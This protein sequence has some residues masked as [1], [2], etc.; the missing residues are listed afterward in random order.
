MLKS[1]RLKLL[2]ALKATLWLSMIQSS[3]T[4][5]EHLINGNEDGRG[6][7]PEPASRHGWAVR[8]EVLQQQ[9]TDSP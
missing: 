5:Q 3:G 1:V 7:K 4:Q 6:V 9:G 8:T 2:Q